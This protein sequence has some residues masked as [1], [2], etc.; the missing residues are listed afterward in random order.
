MLLP[1]GSGHAGVLDR[2]V[3][4]LAGYYRVVAMSS[5]VASAAR[6]DTITGEQHP[7][8]HA[9]DTLALIEKLFDEPPTVFGFSAGG[10]TTLELLARH[11]EHVHLAVVHEPPVTVLLPDAEGH[12]SALESVRAA[13]RTDGPA[14]AAPLMTAIMTTAG[15]DAT[16]AA[17]HHCGDWLEGYADTHPEPPTPQLLELFTR[18]AGLQPL[19]LEHILVPFATNEVQLA[20]LDAAS[21]RLIPVAGIDSR[22]Q[23]PYRAAAALAARLDLPLTELPGGHL[24][25]VERPTQF[26]HALRALLN[27]HQG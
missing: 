26:A 14:A 21:A 4:H 23:L 8:V 1:G 11:P 5:R 7:K 22:G 27:E 16:P 17:L 25:P 15:T 3:A 18:L 12:R 9:E 19:F 13:A 6:P 24:G 2:L 20:A 10:I